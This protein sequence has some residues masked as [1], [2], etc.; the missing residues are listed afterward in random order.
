MSL[1][2]KPK[3]FQLMPLGHY[4]PIY[5]ANR[6]LREVRSKPIHLPGLPSVSQN[7]PHPDWITY[8]QIE[9]TRI[10]TKPNSH[11][12]AC[13]HEIKQLALKDV[14]SIQEYPLSKEVPDGMG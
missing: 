7:H 9:T 8:G 12:I 10:G 4:G 14:R 3:K 11:K 2:V 1:T 6:T 5:I 13:C